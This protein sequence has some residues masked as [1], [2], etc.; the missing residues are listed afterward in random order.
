MKV[1]E[2]A[3]VPLFDV[4]EARGWYW[5]GDQLYAPRGSFAVRRHQERELPLWQLAGV[6]GRMSKKLEGLRQNRPAHLSAE[7]YA[8]FLSDL[9]ALVSISRELIAGAGAR[10]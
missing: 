3:R 8:A 5:D 9:E 6:H 7:R 10:P 1:S 4:L 2:Q